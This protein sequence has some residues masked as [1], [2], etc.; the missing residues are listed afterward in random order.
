MLGRAGNKTW[1]RPPAE[2]RGYAEI[3]RQAVI[4]GQGNKFEIWNETSW[5]KQRDD[6]LESIG[7]ESTSSSDSLGSL[8][9]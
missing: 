4:L 3:K 7:N 9:L 5:E 1:R 2:L 6:W 8:S